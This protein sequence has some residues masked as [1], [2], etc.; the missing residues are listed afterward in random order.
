[1]FCDSDQYGSHLILSWFRSKCFTTP[2]SFVAQTWLNNS[3]CIVTLIKMPNYCYLLCESCSYGPRL[4][5]LSWFRS[6]CFTTNLCFVVQT[7][8]N[9][10]ICNVTEE[11]ASLLLFL[12]HS[13]MAHDFYLYYDSDQNDSLLLIICDSNMAQ[14]FC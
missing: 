14:H 6:K 13:N 3:I 5:F 2:V 4:L 9:N 11:N 12:T 1:M 10:S 8:F 7:W